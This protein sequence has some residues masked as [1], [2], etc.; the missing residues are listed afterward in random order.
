LADLRPLVPKLLE[1]FSMTKVG[2]AT[3]IAE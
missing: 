1:S 2:E 3:L